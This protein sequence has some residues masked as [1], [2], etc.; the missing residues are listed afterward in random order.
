MLKCGCIPD[1]YWCSK[2]DIYTGNV[3]PWGAGEMRAEQS[4]KVYDDE[5]YEDYDERE[6]DCCSCHL[7]APCGYCEKTQGKEDEET[8]ED[9]LCE[10][11]KEKKMNASIEE[12]VMNLNKDLLSDD[13]FIAIDAMKNYKSGFSMYNF[14]IESLGVKSI[15]KGSCHTKVNV[16]KI[17]CFSAGLPIDFVQLQIPLNENWW[18]DWQYQG[19]FRN[20]ICVNGEL[21][22]RNV[23]GI[24]FEKRWLNILP[25]Y[26]DRIS[27][28]GYI[29]SCL[30]AFE[31]WNDGNAFR[32]T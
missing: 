26:I 19:L 27:V 3:P 4:R 22:N 1:A 21:L 14:S 17:K 6:P 5:F 16:I 29:V 9:I 8:D 12:I 2:H 10:V 30:N 11:L 28:Y 15:K 25:N 7:G 32:T 24:E 18:N 13:F 23:I 31:I 20:N